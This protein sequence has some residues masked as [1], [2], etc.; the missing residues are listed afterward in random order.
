MPV[1]ST[2]QLKASGVKVALGRHLEK[3]GIYD[4]LTNSN[5]RTL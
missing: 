2:A 1:P 5:P 3:I 4:S